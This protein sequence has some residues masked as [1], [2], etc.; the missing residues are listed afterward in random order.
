MSGE[1]AIL[2]SFTAC[3]ALLTITPD[4]DTLLVLTM[5][6]RHPAERWGMSAVALGLAGCYLTLALT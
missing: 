4:A 1:L 6:G 5:G 2:L 3:A